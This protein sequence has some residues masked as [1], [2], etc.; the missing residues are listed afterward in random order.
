MKWMNMSQQI[1]NILLNMKQTSQ[2]KRS[3][4][5]EVDLSSDLE[6]TSEFLK[7][8]GDIQATNPKFHSLQRSGC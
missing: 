1:E 7:W 3:D 5:T 2:E 6:E 8:N 4:F